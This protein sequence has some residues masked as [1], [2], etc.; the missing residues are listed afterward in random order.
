[1]QKSRLLSEIAFSFPSLSP[2]Y[3][4]LNL[5]LYMYA[6]HTLPLSHTAHAH[7]AS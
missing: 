1:M 4:E 3:K 6:L 7:W 2:L 5:D